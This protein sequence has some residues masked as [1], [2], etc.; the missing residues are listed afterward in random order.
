MDKI[1]KFLEFSSIDPRLYWR[2]PNRDGQFVYE[3]QWRRDERSRWRVRKLGALLWD[4][5]SDESL[6]PLLEALQIDVYLFEMKLKNSLMQQVTFAHRIVEDARKLLGSDSIDQA[7][8]EQ[9]DFLKQLEVA[10]LKLTQPRPTQA[11]RPQLRM[12]KN[13]QEV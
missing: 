9:Q 7:I 10:L 13:T 5:S 1:L 11:P 8:A 4:L 2:I 3:I 6:V 12:L